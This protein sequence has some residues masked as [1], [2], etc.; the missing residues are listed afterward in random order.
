MSYTATGQLRFFGTSTGN[1]I[2]CATLTIPTS[3][4]FD[5]VG[6]G[7][8]LSSAFSNDN[9]LT[10]KNGTLDTNS[11]AVQSTPFV[12]G[13]GTKTL[14]LGSTEW[15]VTGS[16]SLNNLQPT[17]LTV[18]ANTAV[19]KTQVTVGGTTTIT[20]GSTNWNGTSLWL[21]STNGGSYT[22]TGANTFA[23]IRCNEGTTAHTITFPNAT[24][25]VSTFTV[26]GT[27]GHLV[28]LQ[29]TGGSGSFTLAKAGGGTVTCNYVSVSNSTASPA[30]TFV[31]RSSIDGGG[32]SG[33]SFNT[34]SGF[35]AFF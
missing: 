10:L 24:T 11:K 1:T 27:A 26:S 32:N 23:D 33:W 34:P 29:R 30:S 15:Y 9:A 17:G 25:T 2:D 4:V 5:G 28:T 13:V 35:A 8:T 19:F 6:G 18:T 22:I 7:W 31:A 16:S 3:V 14:T 12:T 20:G 21:A